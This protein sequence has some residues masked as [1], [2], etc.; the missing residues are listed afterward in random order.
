MTNAWIDRG[1]VSVPPRPLAYAAGG[2]V[3]LLAI[4]GLAL[5]FRATLRAAS[6]PEPIAGGTSGA[7]SDAIVAG[8]IVQPP[9]PVP[10]TDA[11][12]DQAKADA[13]DAARAKADDIASQTAAAQAVQSQPSKPAG[14]IDTILASP[15]EKP[16]APVKAP[17]EEAPPGT[18]IKSDVPF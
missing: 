5:G 6:A 18:P 15:T 2:L 13:A 3:L 8:P 17:P 10:A 7:P 11:A 1:P 4:V 14:N 9:P 16:P 12:A